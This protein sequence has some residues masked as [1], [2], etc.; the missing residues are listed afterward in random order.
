MKTGTC[1]KCLAQTIFIE[2]GHDEQGKKFDLYLCGTCDNFTR[3]FILTEREVVDH[4][5]VTDA[6][7]DKPQQLRIFPPGRV[8]D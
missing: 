4:A 8:S 6:L 7:S 1:G 5:L 3:D 2:S